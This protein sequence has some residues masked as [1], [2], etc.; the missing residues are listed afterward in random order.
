[1]IELTKHIRISPEVINN[2]LFL[3]K[4]NAGTISGDSTYDPCC[5][6]TTT[7]TTSNLTGLTFVYSSMTQLLSGGTDGS[8]LLT[9]LTIPI[10]LTET[11]TD[12]GYYSVFDGMIQQ[13]DVMT[14]FIFTGDSIFP[15]YTV[16]LY[17]TSENELKKYLSFSNYQISW[18]DGS[19]DPVSPYTPL[20]I[21][22]TYSSPGDYIISMSGMSPWGYNLIQKNVSIPITGT[23]IT[24]PNGTAYFTPLGGSWSATPLMY[25]YIFSGDANCDA[26]IDGFNNFQSGPLIITGYTKSILSDLQVYG[27]KNSPNLIGGKYLPDFPVTGSSGAIGI[28]KSPIPNSDYTAYTVNNI[29]YYDY[30]DGTTIFIVSGVSSVDYVCSAIT[31]NEALLNVVFEPEVQSNVFI[32]R[33][34]NSG[35]ERLI[36]LGEIDNIGDLENYGYGFFNIINT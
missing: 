20:P 34:K 36:R 12:F 11:A 32:E 22:H 7:T 28:V 5:D 30:S 13:Q 1:M 29:D 3:V 24:N 31:K 10:L 6:I 18:G 25:D 14:N 33:G 17:N 19:S 15:Y 9:G 16:V 2:D 8:S 21:T 23:T 35:L 4:Y 26:T 27:A